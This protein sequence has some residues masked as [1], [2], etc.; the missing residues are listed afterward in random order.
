MHNLIKYMSQVDDFRNVF[1]LK[2]KL[3]DILTIAVLAVL[4]GVDTWDDME[5]Y[6]KERLPLLK[7]FLELPAGIPSLDTFN[8]VFSLID[9]K[10]LETALQEWISSLVSSLPPDPIVIDGKSLRGSNKP[11]AHSFVHRVSAFACSCGLSLAQIKVDEKS[12]EITAI[13]KSLDMI[14]IQG[15]T[16]SIDAIGCQKEIAAKIISKKAHYILAIKDNQPTLR[17]DALLMA[18]HAHPDDEYMDVDAGHGRVEK[19]RTRI[20]RDTASINRFRPGAS[21]LFELI[22]HVTIRP[23]MSIR[24]MRLVST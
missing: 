11:T 13:P 8:R 23:T 22:P 5:L 20:Y 12:N 19:R 24:P 2:N 3:V 10:S 9:P 18:K 17:L 21:L 7:K 1:N 15:C 4:S 16:I 6:G 14:D